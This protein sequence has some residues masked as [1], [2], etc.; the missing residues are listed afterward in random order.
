MAPVEPT[1]G[2]TP[3]EALTFHQMAVTLAKA[4]ELERN[5]PELGDPSSIRGEDFRKTLVYPLEDAVVDMV[6]GDDDPFWLSSGGSIVTAV[7][8]FVA[9]ESGVYSV[10]TR[11]ISPRPIRWAMDKCLRVVTCPVT[12]SEIGTRRSLALELDAGEHVLEVTLPPGAKLD[13]VDIQRRDGSSEEYLRVVEDEGFKLGSAEETVRRRDALRAARRLRDRFDRLTE[14]RCGDEL[15]ALEAQAIALSTAASSSNVGTL[16][17]GPNA[18][19]RTPQ[20]QSGTPLIPPFNRDNGVPSS[21]VEP[22]Q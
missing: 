6:D 3:L 18:P 13:R 20:V 15:I 4:L 16:A 8:R 11:Y 7:A 14:L 9:P 22:V 10:E 2:W 12:P 19:P 1:G 5:L 17:R 21:P